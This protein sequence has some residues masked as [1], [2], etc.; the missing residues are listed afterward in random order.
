MSYTVNA[1]LEDGAP[2]LRLINSRSGDTSL[3][4]DF[5]KEVQH[6]EQLY[7]Q[8]MQKLFKQLLLL[9]CADEH[10]SA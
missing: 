2:R 3:T 5:P 8:E 9:A 7:K 1:W 6:Q 4:W 10:K